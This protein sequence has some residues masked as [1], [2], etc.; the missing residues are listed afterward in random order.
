[1]SRGAHSCQLNY[2]SRKTY[3]FTAPTPTHSAHPVFSYGLLHC[4]YRL[5]QV[6][7]TDQHARHTCVTNP[8]EEILCPTSC[9]HQHNPLKHRKQTPPPPPATKHAHVICYNQCTTHHP[10]PTHPHKL[11]NLGTF[12]KGLDQIT[13]TRPPHSSHCQMAQPL[14]TSLLNPSAIKSTNSPPPIHIQHNQLH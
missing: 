4:H 10:L 12:H 13:Q 7:Y 1:M 9:S 8:I 3:I 11:K 14:P 5:T 2:V 6:Q